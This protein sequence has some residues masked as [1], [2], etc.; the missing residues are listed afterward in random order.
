MRVYIYGSRVRGCTKDGDPVRPDSDLDVAIELAGEDEED[1]FQ[2][3]MDVSTEMKQQLKQLLQ[4]PLDLDW[5]HPTGSPNVYRYV[6][7]CGEVVYPL[8]R[9]I[10]PKL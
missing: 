3:F 1:A 5:Y 6:N 8:P 7:Q 2:Q 9:D 10:T 4:W